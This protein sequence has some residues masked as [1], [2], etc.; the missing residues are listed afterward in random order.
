[1]D[2]STVSLPTGAFT[3][4]KR[5]DFEAGHQLPGLPPEHKCSRQHGHSY[6]VEVILTP[7]G[8]SLPSRRG[9][10]RRSAL[11]AT[12]RSVRPDASFCA[13][14]AITSRQEL[15]DVVPAGEPLG[16]GLLRHQVEALPDSTRMGGS[17]ESTP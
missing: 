14:R 13:P 2:F 10:S 7:A 12:L 4:G 5:F 8:D 1:M 6:E 9:R 16:V 3:I 15:Q 17:S 11:P